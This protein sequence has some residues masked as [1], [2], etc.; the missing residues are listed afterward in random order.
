M[1][2][3]KG[4]V[5]MFDDNKYNPFD[6]NEDNWWSDSYDYCVAGDDEEAWNREIEKAVDKW[7]P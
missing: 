3:T 5:V 6:D 4:V 1:T 2:K 7:E